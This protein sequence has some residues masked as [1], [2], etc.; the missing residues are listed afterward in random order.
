MPKDF[1]ASLCSLLH[2]QLVELP[3]K[4]FQPAVAVTHYWW[5][6]TSSVLKS[7]SF[8]PFEDSSASITYISLFHFIQQQQSSV[9][10]NVGVVPPRR[11]VLVAIAAARVYTVHS[12][13]H[14]VSWPPLHHFVV[15]IML[16]ALFSTKSEQIKHEET[17]SKC[18]T[19]D[20]LEMW[21]GRCLLPF[22]WLTYD[23]FNLHTKR[24]SKAHK[25]TI[26]AN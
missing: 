7:A 1:T 9:E 21:R 22:I 26:F 2:F 17:R 13:I 16:S 18:S 6:N 19:T 10:S 4:P 25:Q 11:S 5:N 23:K 14:V 24:A 8:S 3:R 12:F 20:W 15:I